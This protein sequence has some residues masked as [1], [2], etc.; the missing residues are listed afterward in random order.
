MREDLVQKSLAQ[1][2]SVSVGPC[3]RAGMGLKYPA[4]LG[5]HAQRWHQAYHLALIDSWDWVCGL[6]SLGPILEAP[7]SNLKW[8][9]LTL[10]TKD[11]M[12]EFRDSG[13]FP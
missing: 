11:S 7:T 1:S 3:L 10:W 6:D 4:K 2:H 8:P 9:L 13:I 5:P 12:K